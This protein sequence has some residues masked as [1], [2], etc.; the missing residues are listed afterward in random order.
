MTK[1]KIALNLLLATSLFVLAHILSAIFHLD[2]TVFVAWIGVALMA[3]NYH[4]SKSP[5]SNY[6]EEKTFIGLILLI[7]AAIVFTSIAIVESVNVYH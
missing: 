4:K 3:Q 1:V 5:N 2:K 6:N 7:L